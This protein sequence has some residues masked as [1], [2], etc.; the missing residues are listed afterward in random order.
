M[1]AIL[2]VE[3]EFDETVT[4]AEAVASALDSLMETALSTPGIL[5]EV[6]GP[7]VGNLQVVSRPFPS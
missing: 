5:D 2:E 6:G 3:I 1:K 7:M 4:D